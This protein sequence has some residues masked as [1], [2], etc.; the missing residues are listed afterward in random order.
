[1]SFKI[2]ATKNV[3]AAWLSLLVHLVTGFFLSAFI[4]HKVGDVA[5]GLWVLIFSLTGYYGLF[6]F[7]IRAS[8]VPNVARF[9]AERDEEW[10]T[11]FINTSLAA[12]SII[13]QLVL[14]VTV[15]AR[16]YL[17]SLFRIP[18]NVTSH[19]SMA[20]HARRW[21]SCAGLSSERLFRSSRR[22][23]EVLVA[24]FDPSVSDTAARS[25]HWGHA[26]HGKRSVVRLRGRRGRQR[27]E[28]RSLFRD[29]STPNSAAAGKA[30][31]GPK[32]APFDDF[33]YSSTA[34]LMVAADSF[35]S[36]RAQSSSE[37]SDLLLPLAIV[38]WG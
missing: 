1:M 27:S 13:A 35:A 32:H 2:E 11:R 38:L 19:G 21:G 20:T 25:A 30:V 8:I 33:T 15:L 10:L 14:A 22:I 36:N 18:P 28:L 6:D 26:G 31:R 16:F 29:G 3:G 4:L 34:F 7:G 12:C 24:K 17:G 9:A 37:C 23:R 5:F